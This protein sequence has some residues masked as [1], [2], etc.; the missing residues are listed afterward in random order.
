MK[1]FR[2]YLPEDLLIPFFGDKDIV[3]VEIGV[4]HADGSIG[5]LD[6]MPNLKLYSVDPW[7]Y[8]PGR[9]YEAE[10]RTI[11]AEENQKEQDRTYDEVIEKLEKYGDRSVVVRAKSDDAIITE[12]LDFVW[13]DGDHNEDTVRRDILNWKDKLKKR[14]ILCGHDWRFEHIQGAVREL[15]GEP[16]LGDDD[17]WYFKYL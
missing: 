6:S 10:D 16:E 5:L 2:E 13:I 12:P 3:G 17:I 4:W 1:P 8:Q 11:T 7:L 15:L 14:S 9:G